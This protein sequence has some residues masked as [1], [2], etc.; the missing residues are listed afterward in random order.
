[1]D[2]LKLKHQILPLTLLLALPVWLNHIWLLTV[3]KE[4][5][6]AWVCIT[7]TERKGHPNSYLLPLNLVKKKKPV[8]IFQHMFLLSDLWELSV[9]FS[10]LV[11]Q[12]C[13][14][15]AQQTSTSIPSLYCR[16]CPPCSAGQWSCNHTCLLSTWT[17]LELI[18]EGFPLHSFHTELCECVW[19]CLVLPLEKIWQKRRN[20][21]LLMLQINRASFFP[22]NFL[23]SFAWRLEPA[24]GSG[25][26]L[27]CMCCS[28]FS[29]ICN[30]VIQINSYRISTL[31]W[32]I[33]SLSR[34]AV[35]QL[36]CHH[37][38]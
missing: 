3:R 25:Q 6:K 31:T 12:M 38:Q 7:P 17:R 29:K 13:A 18:A 1:M 35:T 36:H 21:H 23:P 2:S 19:N 11:S 14:L 32:A 37:L 22:S 20:C 28:H 30:Q 5:L 15:R 16:H 8:L 33:A 34:A 10:N 27:G 26:S 4:V 9:S 24:S